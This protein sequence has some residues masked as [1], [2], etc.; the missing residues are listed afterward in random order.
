M[1]IA[2]VVARHLLGL[3]ALGVGDLVVGYLS[4]I[5]HLGAEDAGQRRHRQFAVEP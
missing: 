4:A 2:S 1:R 3:D 5:D